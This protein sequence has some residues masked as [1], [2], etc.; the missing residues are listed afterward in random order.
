M[1]LEWDD[2]Q[3]RAWVK[4]AFMSS[5]KNDNAAVIQ[6]LTR[7]LKLNPCVHPCAFIPPSAC[8]SLRLHLRPCVCLQMIV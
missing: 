7:A 5:M 1:Q 8:L 3:V 6:Y 4:A 2:T